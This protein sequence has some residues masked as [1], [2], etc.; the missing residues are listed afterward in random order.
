[1][2]LPKGFALLTCLTVRGGV[3]LTI[4]DLTTF[5]F[6]VGSLIM[7]LIFFRVTVEILPEAPP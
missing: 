4:F 5:F 1:M 7:P 3:S 6:G 2:V